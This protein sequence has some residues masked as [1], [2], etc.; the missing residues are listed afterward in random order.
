MFSSDDWVE[1]ES[2]NSPPIDD[3]QDV[4]QR[5]TLSS[6]RQPPGVDIQ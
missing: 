3:V 4:V 2:G 5:S 1:V 6:P